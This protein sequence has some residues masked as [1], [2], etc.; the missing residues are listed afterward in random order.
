MVQLRQEYDRFIE[1]ETEIIVVGPDNAAA[2]R[3]Y[4]T[5]NNLPYIGL[6][7]PKHSVLKLYG[8]EI[9]LFK[10]GR[11]PAQVVVDKTGLARYAH[12]GKS[13]SDIPSNDEILTSLELAFGAE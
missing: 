8:Q 6:P 5:E 12:Y 2:F 4:W 1:N 11:M 9:K 13:M 3:K 10:L 7:D